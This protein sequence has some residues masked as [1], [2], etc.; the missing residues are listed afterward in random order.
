MHGNILTDYKIFSHMHLPVASQPSRR[1]QLDEDTSST[2]G[3]AGVVGLGLAVAAFIGFNLV[4]TEETATA[5]EAVKEVI[6]KVAD[7]PAAITGKKFWA[8]AT[9]SEPTEQTGRP[10]MSLDVL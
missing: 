6:G 5:Q 4:A 9:T 10:C 8:L 7:L 2:L 1:L 3:A